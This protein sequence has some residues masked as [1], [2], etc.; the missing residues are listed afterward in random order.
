[1]SKS[2]RELAKKVFQISCNRSGY[3]SKKLNKEI[4]NMIVSKIKR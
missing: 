3:N 1:M 2:K 4:K